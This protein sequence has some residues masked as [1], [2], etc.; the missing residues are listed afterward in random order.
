MM[1]VRLRN[2][3]RT[4]Q[5]HGPLTVADLLDHLDIVPHTVLVL[6]AGELVTAERE[7][8][9]TAEVEVRPVMSGG[10]GAAPPRVVFFS[11]GVIEEPRHRA[12]WCPG[13]FTDHVQAQ[14]RKAIDH[15]PGGERSERM[16]SY[17]DRLLVAV[18]GGK[19]SLALWDV[20]LALGYQVEGL[21]VGLGIG[22]Y[23]SRSQAICERFAAD[24]QVRLHV[25]DL[26]ATY[27]YTTP[28]GAS[29]TGR[30]TCGVC[31]LSKRYVFNQVAVEHGYDVMVTGHNLDDEAATLLGNV[32]RW[33]DDFLARQRPVLPT[34]GGN[35]VR[36]VKPLYR[37]SEREMAAYCVVRGIDYVVE[38]CPL[39]DGNT[40]QD[41]KAALDLLEAGAP[42]T[43]A[44]FLFGFLDRHAA[45]FAADDDQGVGVDLCACTR[46]GMPTTTEVCAF[47]RQR[48]RITA[49]LPTIEV[50]T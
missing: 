16:F 49:V 14:V 40:G 42:G 8:P 4:E 26:A 47:C 27:G 50:P 1:R 46:C 31:G 48:E 30:S 32:L 21:Y 29:A 38:E 36:K 11:L 12:A 45:W 28:S 34:T 35:Q 24:R 10:G 33:Q 6:H 9:D 15:P 23:S 20:L 37:L 5:V 44:Q 18:S 17:G 41:L 43:K 39:V 13:H 7:L 22:G 25:V 3:D 19:D 2:P